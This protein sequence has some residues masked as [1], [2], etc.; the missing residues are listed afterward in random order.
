MYTLFTERIGTF[1]SGTKM[2]PNPRLLN[3]ADGLLRA[4]LKEDNDHWRKGYD[5]DVELAFL[6]LWS[7]TPRASLPLSAHIYCERAQ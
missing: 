6:Q 2:R 1:L 4:A 3:S 7:E 5:L